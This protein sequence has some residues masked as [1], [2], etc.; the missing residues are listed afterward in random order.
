MSA[1]VWNSTITTIRTRQ[2]SP[3]LHFR[4][5]VG[6]YTVMISLLRKR[7]QMNKNV[8]DNLEEDQNSSSFAILRQGNKRIYYSPL[9]TVV[10]IHGFWLRNLHNFVYFEILVRQPRGSS[11]N[12]QLIYHHCRVL[13]ILKGQNICAATSVWRGRENKEN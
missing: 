1:D 13:E 6:R 12:V 2:K 9:A 8:R 4:P 7:S 3:T 11:I 10:L 5:R